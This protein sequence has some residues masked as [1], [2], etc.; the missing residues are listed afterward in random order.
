MGLLDRLE[1]RAIRDAEETLVRHGRTRE[2]V[3]ALTAVK[4]LLDDSSP[5]LAPSTPVVV[6]DLHGTRACPW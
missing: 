6:R 5:A 2:S 4:P 3:L 1:D